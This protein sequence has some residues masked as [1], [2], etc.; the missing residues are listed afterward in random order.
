MELEGGKLALTYHLTHLVRGQSR[1]GGSG[2][3]F[4]FIEDPTE[5]LLSE[6]NDPTG[7]CAHHLDELHGLIAQQGYTIEL[8]RGPNATNQQVR[9]ALSNPLVVGVYYFGHGFVPHNGTEGR[10]LLADG[11]LLARQIAEAAPTA[12][13]VFLNACE[14]AAAGLEWDLEKGYRSVAEAFARGA[15][16]KVVI[17]P[18]WPVVSVQA[19][20]TA[21][22]FFRHASQTSPLAEALKQAR[23]YSL[24][25]YEAGEPH[26][27]WMAYRY[28]GNPNM[29]LP[30][31]AEEP[32]VATGVP[33]SRVFD[34]DG[35]LDTE[36]FACAIDE[37]LLRAAKR[38]NGQGRTR[39]TITDVL[40][41]MIRKGDLT[42]FVL[43]QQG[44]DPD[45]LY[46]TIGAR[47]E[48]ELGGTSQASATTDVTASGDLEH[49]DEEQLRERLAKWIVRRQEEFTDDLVRLLEQ[50]DQCAQQR[51]TRT[52]DR[53][54][55]E[56]DLLESLIADSTWAMLLPLGL[57]PASE[58][59]RRLQ[60]RASSGTI[61]ENGALSLASLDP[62]AR[63]VIATAHTQAQQRGICPITN[64]VLFAA[65]LTEEEGYAARV[66]RRAGGD[67]ELLFG[68]MIIATEEHPPRS[69]GL[70]PEACERIVMPVIEEATRSAADARAITEKELFRAFCEQAD[71]GFKEWLK[72]PCDEVGLEVDLDELKLMDLEEPPP[73][74]AAPE[75]LL[76]E[77]DA[78]AIRIV[79]T[80]HA[81]A[82]EQGIYPISNR[83]MLAAFLTDLHGYI[84]RLFKKH[85][86]PAQTLCVELL[87]AAGG[88]SPQSF[89]L[90]R[91]AGERVVL[92][93]LRRARAL[94]APTGR[95][96]EPVLFKAFCEV[97][98]PALKQALKLPPWRSDLEAL[99][100]E[101]DLPSS[102]DMEEGGLPRPDLDA[103]SSYASG[104]TH[105]GSG[106]S[107]RGSDDVQRF[108]RGQFEDSA[109][110]AL[111]ESAQLA[112]LQGGTVIRTPHLF[113]ALIGDGSGPVGV[114][115][116]R[117]HV[118]AEEMKARVLSLVPPQFL[119]PGAPRTIG[120]GEHAYQVVR[121]AL[122][123]AAAAGR[124]Q[125]TEEDLLAAFFAD[126][127]GVVGDLLRGLG[128]EVLL[129]ADGKGVAPHGLN[130]G[131]SVLSALG[132]DLTEKAR[133]GQLPKVVG[134][135]ADI[136]TAMHTLLL[137]E[138]ANPLL[139]GEAGVGKT[140]IV[141]GLAQRLVQGRCP[142]PLRSMCIIELSAGGLV[143]N[144]RLRGEFEQRM[145]EVL[146][147][148]REEQVILFIDEIH[149]IVG[150]GAAEGSGPDAGNM[151][152]AA[153][154][155]GEIRLIGA[156]TLAEYRR[157][158]ARD[159]ALSRRFQV[160]RIG[161]PSREATLQVLS[162]RQAALEQHHN[163]C[164]TEE[165]KSAAVDRSGRYL[166][167]SQWPAKARDVLERSCVLART[168]TETSST[169]GVVP[170]TPE[171]VAQVVSRQ[172]GI[173]L[174]RVS[175][176]DLSALATLE[177]QL[178]KRIV[179]QQHA[180]HMIAEAIRRGR[181]GLADTKRPWGVFF[182]VGPPG[183]GKT[184]LARVL[185]EEVYGGPDGLI[186]FDMG[187]FTEP[188][189]TAR[190]TGSPPGY[191]A[192]EQGA[193]LVE[194]LRTHP[195]CLLL[196]DEIEHAHENVLAVLLRLLSEGTLVDAD[197]NVADARNA[198]VI[199]TSNVLDTERE[200][201]RVGFTQQPTGAPAQPSQTALRAAL[202]PHFSRQFIDRLDAII[203]FR[204]LTLGDL[205][206]IAGQRVREVVGRVMAR[207]GVPVSV[208]P[209]VLPWL[210]QKAASESVG[211]RAIQRTVDEHVGSVLVTALSHVG[212]AETA[213]FQL[214][215][216]PDQSGTE[217]IPREEHGQASE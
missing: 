6:A 63:A 160:Q 118:Q 207:H 89:P 188:Y 82:Q 132:S 214:A 102:S 72:Q 209:E 61:D 213:C 44:T 135:D 12:K 79:E 86:I 41:G 195:Y 59:H 10:L 125:V 177:K 153:L 130:R 124:T 58:V 106:G 69:F 57:P 103:A 121:G 217:C 167:D 174:E 170:V 16:T 101:A 189:A 155:R 22:E 15:P 156:T 215:V 193:P 166:V 81:L 182:F 90:D 5:E 36:V 147:A 17:A 190:L 203:R 180:V 85:H 40:A 62:T 64:R 38:R 131:A 178:G 49:L 134:R 24:R 14:G 31:L 172:T 122:Q 47:M 33:E 77:L 201:T 158:I 19:A 162:A 53:R 139:V 181:Q 109:W 83:L 133:R 65:F 1:A 91:E 157:T 76:E 95:V 192:Y 119:P 138:N 13:F 11:P 37:I 159:K 68:L 113:A 205:Q 98:E 26:L 128:L 116:Q 112:R 84:T 210:A 175:A 114:A 154:A 32:A 165:A 127:G 108:R 142:E 152:K 194:R 176:S 149:T 137:S 169:A 23:Q 212:S 52:E 29:T 28:F 43:R 94:V 186:R 100:S 111:M 206:V 183:V 140:A 115:L 71:S 151:L 144:T 34:S 54:I 199:M 145:Q 97:A 3:R 148:A 46:D 8:Y 45:E 39:V 146:A 171:H 187:D 204:P 99:G 21:L 30:V 200:S 78:A 202:E 141:E 7:V 143:A 107:L 9:D 163:V 126:G 96:T 129:H 35:Q 123:R 117:H 80:A 42:R 67:P 120:L 87:A 73:P 27:M 164:I 20:E 136:E 110:R 88:G 168:A 184:E 51:S 55:A 2:N 196:F 191:V 216:R 18:L 66:C 105:P 208:S 150:A 161:P 60:E 74:S 4:L 50:T 48:A 56:Q 198:I 211:A 70:S 93:M 25:H 75:D 104:P 179:G 197:G 173:P 185:A 92:P